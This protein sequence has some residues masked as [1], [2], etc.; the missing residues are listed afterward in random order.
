MLR[1][2]HINHNSPSQIVKNHCA[3]YTPGYICAGAIIRSNGTSVL[4]QELHNQPCLIKEGK[5]CDYY[6]QFIKPIL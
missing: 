3:N 6:N 4:D 2:S 1:L 5:E